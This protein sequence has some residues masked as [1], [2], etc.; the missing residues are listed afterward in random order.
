MKTAQ[1][2]RLDMVY[3]YTTNNKY[4]RNAKKKIL[5]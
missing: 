4:D 5:K 1:L 3:N 2:F